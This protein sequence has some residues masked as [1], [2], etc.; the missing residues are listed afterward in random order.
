MGPSAQDF[1]AAFGLGHSDRMISTVD[2]DGVALAAIQGLNR[3]LEREVE[4]LAARNADLE[5]ALTKLDAK[6]RAF[7]ASLQT[8]I[9]SS[10][11]L[12]SQP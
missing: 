7:E 5:T 9:A 12:G 10:I 1:R 3:K 11:H 4:S 2:A 6:L 8:A